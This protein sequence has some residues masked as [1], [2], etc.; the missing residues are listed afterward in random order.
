MGAEVDFPI[1][2]EIV[3]SIRKGARNIS[4]FICLLMLQFIFVQHDMS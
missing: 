1:T 3:D 4:Y 2:S